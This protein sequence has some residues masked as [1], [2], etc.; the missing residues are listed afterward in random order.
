MRQMERSWAGKETDEQSVPYEGRHI[1]EVMGIKTTDAEADVES[2][3]AA[4]EVLTIKPLI[5][6]LGSPGV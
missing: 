3:L 6:Y 5:R 1:L 4:I 2:F